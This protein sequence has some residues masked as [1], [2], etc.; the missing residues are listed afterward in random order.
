[1]QRSPCPCF[2]CACFYPDR[3]YSNKAHIA[4]AALE[5]VCFQVGAA[6][7]V[8][9]SVSLLAQPMRYLNILSVPTSSPAPQAFADS[10]H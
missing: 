9:V 6:L 8:T 4:R 5:A 10:Q 1:M 2:R 3:Q 7:C